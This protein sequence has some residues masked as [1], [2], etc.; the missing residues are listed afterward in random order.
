METVEQF[1]ASINELEDRLD[2]VLKSKYPAFSRTYFQYLIDK[3]SVLVNKKPVKKREQLSLNDLVEITFLEG[4]KSPLTP[5]KMDLDILFEDAHIL[6]INKP[7]GMVVHPAPGHRDMTF[8]NALLFHC[9]HLQEDG[10]LRPGI[11][12][13]LDKETSGVLIAAKNRETQ[14]LLTEQFAKREVEKEYM[15][16]CFGNPSCMTCASPIGRHPVRRQEMAIVEGGKEAHT[17]FVIHSSHKEFSLVTAYPTTGRTHQIRV[18]LKALNAPILGDPLYGRP[19]VNE[20][21]KAQRQLLHAHK[22]KLVHPITKEPMLFEAPLP[23][24]LKKFL[25]DLNLSL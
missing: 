12:H 25:Q 8:V 10:T 2:R 6:V 18:H 1:Y 7:A 20:K 5:Q 17:R 23:E 9:E 3:G 19:S 13:R 4:E 11:V 14:A 21:H 15:A 16:I 22:L 24:D